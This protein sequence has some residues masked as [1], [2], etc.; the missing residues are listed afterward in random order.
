MCLQHLLSR[1]AKLDLNKEMLVKD[2]DIV[3]APVTVVDSQGYPIG[4]LSVSV[5]GIDTVRSFRVQGA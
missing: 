1:Y 4:I 3:N 2:L 5:L